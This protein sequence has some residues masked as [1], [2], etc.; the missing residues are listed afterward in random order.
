MFEQ[1]DHRLA[2]L[3]EKLLHLANRW[4]L[5]SYVQQFLPS[6]LIWASLLL[7]LFPVVMLIYWFGAESGGGWSSVAN[8]PYPFDTHSAKKD[9]GVLYLETLHAISLIFLTTFASI[10]FIQMWRYAQEQTS[11]NEKEESDLGMIWMAAAMICWELSGNLGL[12]YLGTYHV[13]CG[14]ILST[15][16]SV[17]L[18]LSIR[19]FRIEKKWG[20]LQQPFIQMWTRVST[21]LLLLGLVVLFLL[22]IHV[23]FPQHWIHELPDLMIS[24]ITIPMLGIY[25]L[26]IF[27]DRGITALIALTIVTL[28]LIAFSQGFPLVQ[29]NMNWGDTAALVLLES[30]IL[31]SWK[32]FLIILFFAL[33]Y[34]WRENLRRKAEEEAALQIKQERD[35]K[36]ILRRDMNHAIRGNLN[37]LKRDLAQSHS[38][39]SSLDASLRVAS[40]L[41]I[42]DIIHVE[43]NPKEVYLQ[44]FLDFFFQ[45]LIAT[46]DSSLHNT[47]IENALDETLIVRFRLARD[48]ARIIQELSINAFQAFRKN[49]IPPQDRTLSIAIYQ[50]NETIE[51]QVTDNAGGFEAGIEQENFGLKNCRKIIDFLDGIFSIQTQTGETSQFFIS[52][53]I[54]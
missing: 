50:G 3:E 5:P 20:L 1:L 2:R 4:Q 51:L 54:R 47:K 7:L 46:E 42:H 29:K 18:L 8:L 40:M 22:S 21:I 23:F 6:T 31:I 16:N 9:S 52:I 27:S 12:F 38:E 15:F 37:I 43:N 19:S 44:R 49:Q 39:S 36:E 11:T 28:V 17:F 53:P 26:N 25:L 45:H 14:E 24:L 34:S 35:E 10:S 13:F 48:L 30:L 32:I 41:E 33:A